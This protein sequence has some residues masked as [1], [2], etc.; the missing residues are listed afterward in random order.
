M[1]VA[2]KIIKP[3]KEISRSIPL[4]FYGLVLG[5]LILEIWSYPAEA[6]KNNC[7]DNYSSCIVNC[8]T[9]PTGA[10]GSPAAAHRYA[11]FSRC[12]A[13]QDSCQRS[14][15]SASGASAKGP[16]STP[17]NRKPPVITPTNP[18]GAEQPPGGRRPVVGQQP[19]S[20]AGA[21][22][23]PSGAGETIYKGGGGGKH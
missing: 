9:Y 7:F 3:G 11:C 17:P 19:P 22:Q 23:G 6:R 21:N 4:S 13:A 8:N 1:R 2:G 12:A 5:T 15:Q 18:G 20:S 14:A 16:I 10:P